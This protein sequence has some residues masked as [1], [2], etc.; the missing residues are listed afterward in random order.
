MK[1]IIIVGA[2]SG[3]GREIATLHIQRKNKVFLFARREE[4]LE[5]LSKQFSDFNDSIFFQNHDV[6]DFEKAEVLFNKAVEV[7]AGVDEIYYVSGLMTDVHPLEFNTKKDLEM[8]NVNLLGCVAWLNASS[9]YF[10]KE[11]KGK[12]IGISSVTGE[13][14]RRKNPA[15][16]S[17]KA[18]MN[19]YLESLRNRLSVQGIQVSTIKPGFVETEMTE[20]LDLKGAITAKQAALQIVKAVDSKKEVLFV[21]FKWRL[22]CFVLRNIPS[23]I[24]KRLSV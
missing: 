19:T 3:I 12:I 22:I 9:S 20:H 17:A 1:K 16:H 5:E 21:P 14:G 23:F 15:Y 4:R 24:F 13:R 11:K 18:A 10:V 6:T 8:F 7:M 2:S